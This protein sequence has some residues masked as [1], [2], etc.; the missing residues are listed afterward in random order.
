[1]GSDNSDFNDLETSK[2]KNLWLR[3]I[4]TDFLYE[5]VIGAPVSF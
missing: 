1:M 4:L 3:Q 2:I 5:H